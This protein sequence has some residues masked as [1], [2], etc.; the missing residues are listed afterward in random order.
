MDN[1]PSFAHPKPVL[2]IGIPFCLSG[3]TK[4]RSERLVED[5]LCP[6]CAGPGYNLDR[7]RVIVMATVEK[8]QKYIWY[9]KCLG[10]IRIDRR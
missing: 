4:G 8:L 9:V 7:G 3:G 1:I 5:R 10:P 6:P 2:M